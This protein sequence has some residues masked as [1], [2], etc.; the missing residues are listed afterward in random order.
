VPHNFDPHERW[1]VIALIAFFRAGFHPTSRVTGDTMSPY[2]SEANISVKLRFKNIARS[3][4]LF[5]CL[6][7]YN[8]I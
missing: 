3:D 1:T 7:S 4:M 8:R 2:R 5:V 6:T